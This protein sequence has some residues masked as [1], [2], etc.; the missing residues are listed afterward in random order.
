MKRLLAPLVLFLFLPVCAYA[1]DLSPYEIETTHGTITAPVPDGITPDML[2]GQPD[3]LIGTGGGYISFQETEGQPA[4]FLLYDV[5]LRL[6]A[7]GLLPSEYA[8]LVSLYN[9]SDAVILSLILPTKPNAQ[10]LAARIGKDG[11]LLWQHI[12]DYMHMTDAT[13]ALPDGAG[14]A[15]L[16]AQVVDPENYDDYA[17]TKLTHVN[18]QGEPEFSRV[19]KTG[20]EILLVRRAV[21]HSESG[22]VTLYCSLVAKSRNVYTALAV[23]IDPAGN[24]L[25]TQARDFSMRGDTEF[26]FRI[27]QSGVPWVFSHQGMHYGRKGV[28]VPFSEL[29]ALAPPTLSFQ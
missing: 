23:T 7:Q 1:F 20:K 24:I 27:D 14:G 22:S 17:G 29:P 5:D 16:S 11:R 9:D 13:A 15:W 6:I 21:S 10:F 3:N 8:H 12:A 19:L 28:L 25:D 26:D 2:E 18:T 4:G